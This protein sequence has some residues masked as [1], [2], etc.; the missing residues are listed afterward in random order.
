MAKIQQLDA[1]LTNMIAAG[2]VVE[3]PMGVIKELVENALDAKA[4][5]IEVNINQGGTELMEVIDNGVGM[6]R[7]DACLCFER[8]ATSKIKTTEDLWAIHT[9]GFRGEALPS[10]ASVSNLTLLTNNGEDST[11]VEIR[12][13]QRQS[14]RPYPCN[15]G[16]QITV[17]GLFQKTPAR[18]KHLKSIPYETSLILDV[19]QK[20]A[21]SY[22][23]VAFRLVHDG[24][25]VFR[26]A[27]NGSLLEV[28][29]IIYG[30]DL[31]RQCIEVE[32]QDFDYTVRGL[33]ALPAQTRASRNYMTVF[34]NRRMIRSY[35][36]QKA[37]LEAY[38]NYIPQDR[39]PIVVLD[40]EMDSHLCDV[41]V[42]PSKWEIRL[43]KEQ[44]LEFLIRDTLTRTLRE[45]M[46]APEVMRVETPR[47]KVEMPQLFETPAAVPANQVR[48]DSVEANEWRRQVALMSKQREREQIAASLSREITQNPEAAGKAEESAVLPAEPEAL[49]KKT[50]VEN[51]EG[52]PL[53]TPKPTAKTS[54]AD[55]LSDQLPKPEPLDPRVQSTEASAE[56]L[57]SV[58]KQTFPQMQVLAQ[59]HGK[60]I[61]AQDEHALY[62]VDQHAAQE[63]VHFEEVQQRFL[64][65]EPLMQEL[66][67][68]IILEGSA[69]VAARLQEMNELLEPMHIH[70][71]NFGQNS[72]ICRQL[73]AWM[74]E[75]DEQ[76]FL[77]DVLDLWKDG[78]EV[79]AEDL[80][81]HRLATIACHHSIRFNRVLSLGE[82]Q[83]VIE[84][85]ARCEQP[86]HCP[87]GRP[88]FITITEKQ[89]IKEFQR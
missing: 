86:Y 50:E 42:H 34:I 63:R 81:R 45:H 62:I 78:R 70:L 3:R 26:S 2:E 49:I 20:F 84:Q 25:E 47:E 29:A 65:Q 54:S 7:E 33:M 74:S 35:R 12:Y 4:T 41:N 77:Q 18:L 85:L 89:L 61:L 68:P 24:K 46:Q 21:L 43:S 36:I 83:E 30:R 72:L 38:K 22:P 75:I 79:R 14:A 19:I 32:G 27:C 44:Q 57:R 23:D 31:A 10:I 76:A 55:S 69:S 80:Q 5:R 64:D 51:R 59:M 58:P 1:H 15:Q 60:Y 56:A 66:L 9:L 71:E 48:E 8:H 6:D 37:I 52:S 87:H 88:T 73:P 28:M 53:T 16:T 11:R 40:I 82:M 67:V 17:S 13:G 39:Y